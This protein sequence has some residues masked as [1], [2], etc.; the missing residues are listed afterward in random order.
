MYRSTQPAGMAGPFDFL[1]SII[2]A[3]ARLVTGGAKIVSQAGGAV[4]TAQ[5]V[6]TTAQT[7]PTMPINM[8][9]VPAMPIGLPPG[10]PSTQLRIS[11]SETPSWL[12]PVGIV[13]ALIVGGMFFG[14]RR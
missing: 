10:A 12:L 5:R 4:Q 6:L 11:Q 2:S 1:T 7:S 14:R 8:P 13:T 3:G 9:G